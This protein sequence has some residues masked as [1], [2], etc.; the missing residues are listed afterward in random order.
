MEQS[1]TVD[2]NYGLGAALIWFF[3]GA[4]LLVA[5]LIYFFSNSTNLFLIIAIVVVLFYC[6]SQ[7]PKIY[8]SVKDFDRK[9]I[10]STDEVGVYLDEDGKKQ[11]LTWEQIR[12][13]DFLA[14]SSAGLRA[15][16]VRT[17]HDDEAMRV[18]GT[19]FQ[20]DSLIQILKDKQIAFGYVRRN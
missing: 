9:R 19:P 17:D 6:L 4:A 13:Y 12:Q 2:K 11:Q 5:L 8:H 3:P 14:L 16:L 10:Y 18:V 15:I 1:W 7:L 20:I